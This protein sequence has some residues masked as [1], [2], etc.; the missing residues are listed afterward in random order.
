MNKLWYL[1]QISML[2]ALP[3]E[4]LME[5]DEMAPMSTLKKNTLIQTPDTFREGLFFIKEGK[6]RLFKVN[7][8]GKQFTLGI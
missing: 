2:E 5:I 4:D 3:K 6:L 1:S 7:A 8:D